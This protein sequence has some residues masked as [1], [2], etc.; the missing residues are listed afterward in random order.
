MPKSLS[1]NIQNKFG[2]TADLP[3]IIFI[4]KSITATTKRRWIMPPAAYPKNPIAHPITR[5]TAMT[6]NKFPI[7][8]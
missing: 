7:K 8:K 3:P 1:K 5:M 4:K 2:Y 6:Y